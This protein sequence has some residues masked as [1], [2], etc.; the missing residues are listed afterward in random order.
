MKKLN[1]KTAI[2][3]S[4]LLCII[5]IAGI[6]LCFVPMKAGTKTFLSLSG[7]LNVST[8]MMGGMYGEYDI[9]SEDPTTATK[10]DSMAKIKKV[11]EKFGYKNV[12]VY[13]FGSKLRV[14]VSY[15]RGSK[16]YE[17]VFQELSMVAGG[18][19][20]LSSQN[21]NGSTG[22]SE[23][24]KEEPI[25]L[26][27]NEHVENVRVYTNNSVKYIS[28][29]FNEKGQEI[30]KQICDKSS[31]IYL[32]L[33]E[34]YNQQINASGVSDYSSLTLSDEKYENLISLEQRVTIGCMGIDINSDTAIINTMS[35]S[36]FTGSS[37]PEENG[38]TFGTV[39]ILMLV[40]FLFI[41]VALIAIF[42]ARFGLFAVVIA[43]SMLFN[44]FLFL[45]LMV[46][47]PSIEIGIAGVLALSLGIAIIY[48]FTFIFA[49][50]VKKQYDLGKSFRASLETAFKKSLPNTIISNLALFISALIIF[51]FSFGE[52]TSAIVIFAICMALSL[53]TNLLIIPLLVKVGIS[54]RKIDTKLFKLPKRAIGFESIDDDAKEED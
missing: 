31:T 3:V 38:F 9:I 6:L 8:D 14:E 44:S 42:A 43:I 1:Q 28:I 33:G 4:V 35:A 26:N 24:D 39:S 34:N 29:E 16:S 27:G 15:P 53:I 52:L 7:S 40:T 36:S 13:T 25:I 20:K 37:S 30:Y 51:A 32:S 41:V 2:I 23:S 47:M 5:M 48:T 17:K 46:L 49:E 50:N 19:F 10:L 18:S 45:I 54:F 22:S 21:P 11:F 12:N